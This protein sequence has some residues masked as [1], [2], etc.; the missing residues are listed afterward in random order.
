MPRGRSK[1]VATTRTAKPVPG[2]FRGRTPLTTTELNMVSYIE[3]F[4]HSNHVFPP[5]NDIE[6]AFNVEWKTAKHSPTFLLALI[7]RGIKI[8]TESSDLNP[9]QV[10]V[11]LC[12]SNYNDRRTRPAKLRSLGITEA[13]F[14][15]WIKNKQFKTFY[16]QMISANFDNAIDLAQDGLVK[17]MERGDIA[18]IKFYLEYTGRYNQNASETGNVKVILAKVIESIQHHVP[19]PAI[20]AGIASDFEIIMN[21]GTPV[22]IIRELDV[23]PEELKLL[24]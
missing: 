8:P 16:D 10:A 9:D 12:L 17:G 19:D 13:R 18:A 11:V 14:Q 24:D 15:G 6:T 20:L 1:S 5:I 3:Q 22:K 2:D 21:G 23:T 4:W 7:N